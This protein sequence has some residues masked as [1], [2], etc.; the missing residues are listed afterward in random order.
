M[1]DRPSQSE[2]KYWADL[3]RQGYGITGKSV[4]KDPEKAT[5][6]VAP[7]GWIQSAN[8]DAGEAE[9]QGATKLRDVGGLDNPSVASGHCE[10]IDL[11]DEPAELVVFV[12]KCCDH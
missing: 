11:T 1:L 8:R 3:A 12:W 4:L 6:V 7:A 5:R 10:V 9:N 2:A